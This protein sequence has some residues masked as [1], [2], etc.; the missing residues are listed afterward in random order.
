[1]K[2]VLNISQVVAKKMVENNTKGVI[3]NISSQASKVH[4]IFIFI[5][6]AGYVS[7]IVRIKH[8]TLW[9]LWTLILHV[10]QRP[11]QS[12][13]HL[14]FFY[15]AG[16]CLWLW[17]SK[18]FAWTSLIWQNLRWENLSIELNITH[19]KYYSTNSNNQNSHLL[20]SSIINVIIYYIINLFLCLSVIY[21]AAKPGIKHVQITL[22]YPDN[23][24]TVI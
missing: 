16:T 8:K 19:C 24:L 6:T 11:V 14:K 21:I 2:A 5:V 17:S 20:H 23:H 4:N 22:F 10:Q 18:S 9:A 12:H 15:C 7:H 1:M 13:R 3:V